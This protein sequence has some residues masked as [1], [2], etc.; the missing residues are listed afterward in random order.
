MGSLGATIAAVVPA[1]HAIERIAI[2][3]N[4]V[5][6]GVLRGAVL[7]VHLEAREG[8]WRPDR[9]TDPGIVLRAFGERGKRMQIPGPLI[10]VPEGTE[11]RAQ[12]TNTFPRGTLT[13][14]GLST[15]GLG[16]ASAEDTIRIEAGATREVRFAA[17]APGTYYYR[18]S[19][20][21]AVQTDSSSR[22]ALLNGAFVVDA[23]GAPSVARDRVIVLG[24]WTGSPLPGGVV[25]RRTVLRF[26]MN[27]RTWPNTERLSYAVGDTVRL[28]V[29]NSSTAVHPMHL[30]GFYFKVD[31]RGDGR[32][33][34]VYA[35]SA[36]PHLVVTERM[37]PGRTMSM[38]WVPER[39]G[40]WL[41]H[42]H[43]NFHV[44]RSAPL[45]GTPLPDEHTVHVK[46]HALE[47][48]GGL[49][50]GITVRGQA[51]VVSRSAASTRAL[52]LVAQRDSGGTEQEPAY[53]Y[54][55]Q[56]GRAAT[57][58]R[59]SL[60]PAPTIVLQRGVP[61]AI[62][63][64]NRLPEATAVHWHG[65]ELESY[66]DGVAGYSGAGRRLSPAIAPGDSFVAHFTPRRS[67]TFMYHPHADETRQQQA[68]LAGVL[69]VVDSVES[70]DRAHDIP[71]LLTT[72]RRT[73][74]A[75]SA[76]YLNGS[77][78][79]PP[80]ELRAG[81]RYRIRLVDVHTFRPSMIV[82][83]LRDSS[84]VRWRALAKDG[85]DLPA[86]RAVM[87]PSVQ[88]LGN[89]E[90]YDFELSPA[91]GDLDLTVSSAAGVLL[92]RLPIRVR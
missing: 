38:S 46:N 5:P 34:S 18:G 23:R 33:D 60:L 28:R 66:F 16:S 2:N 9:E 87:R 10:R 76:V 51:S 12:V 32:T 1:T 72:P 30:H 42:C 45:D 69:L 29:V 89:G 8:E 48:M 61:A 74:D 68:G 85:M 52:R 73:T 15:R 57:P 11:I 71:I 86:D 91:A 49:V 92:A 24:L 75:A 62:T 78:A 4:R 90:T 7:T 14:V 31:S 19:I 40:N 80:L 77:L 55:L 56:D 53:G 67:G 13:I 59:G 50:M 39:A 88:Q 70:F 81:E 82:R 44:L 63:V 3:D 58:S 47:M 43:D 20:S 35:S 6:A 36:S 17:G 25:G 64:V 54:V 65:M 27:G 41:L 37:P 21:G 83:L 26:T 22:D 79:P 84:L